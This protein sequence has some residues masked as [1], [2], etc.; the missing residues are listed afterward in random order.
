M[1]A[2]T[3]AIKPIAPNLAKRIIG[4]II[5]ASAKLPMG[6]STARKKLRRCPVLVGDE[7]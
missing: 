6:N 5:R 1:T 2:K 3:L 4:E 7:D